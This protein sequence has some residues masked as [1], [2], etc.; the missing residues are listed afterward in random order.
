M[1]SVLKCLGLDLRLNGTSVWP[2]P[3]AMFPRKIR[4]GLTE[5]RGGDAARNETFE[6]QFFCLINGFAAAFNYQQICIGARLAP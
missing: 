3:T 1:R 2:R 5:R 6:V 4:V